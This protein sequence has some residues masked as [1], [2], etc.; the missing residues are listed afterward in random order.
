MFYAERCLPKTLKA[1][2][3]VNH[4]IPKKNHL[5]SK[6]ENQSTLAVSTSCRDCTVQLKGFDSQHIFKLKSSVKKAAKKGIFTRGFESTFDISLPAAGF[7]LN[8]SQP[9]ATAYHM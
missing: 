2:L 7:Q 3:E 9:S 4:S 5:H 6:S 8:P 1:S